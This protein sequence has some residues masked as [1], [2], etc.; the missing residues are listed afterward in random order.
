MKILLTITALPIFLVGVI[1]MSDRWGAFDKA[2][3][4]AFTLV[5]LI[6]LSKGMA[7]DKA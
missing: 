5:S 1:S 6:V 7:N 2:A 4:L 3:L